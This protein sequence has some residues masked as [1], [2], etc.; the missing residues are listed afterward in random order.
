MY[1]P[2][3]VA[4][5][6]IAMLET[7]LKSDLKTFIDTNSAAGRRVPDMPGLKSSTVKLQAPDGSQMDVSAAEAEH[8]IKRG[9]KRVQ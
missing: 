5:S 8:Y 2:A 4:M 9:A 1:D 6:K 7:K 3:D